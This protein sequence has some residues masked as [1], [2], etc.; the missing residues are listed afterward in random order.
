RGDSWEVTS[1]FI[2][3]FYSAA[4]ESSHDQATIGKRLFGMIV[5]GV[6]GRRLTFARA[7]I[8]T[9]AKVLS[10]VICGMGFIMPLLT[11]KKQALHDLMTDVVVVV[12]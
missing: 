2:W 7:A 1:F 9:F 8:R 4:L 12:S 5:C 10:L 3:F 6:D 11:P